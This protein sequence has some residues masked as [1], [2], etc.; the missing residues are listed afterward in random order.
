MKRQRHQI[1]L[2]LVERHALSSQGEV[3]A[4]LAAR[5]VEANQAT[6]SRDINELGLVKVPDGSGGHRYARPKSVSSAVSWEDLQRTLVEHAT[7]V[8]ANESLIV[9]K[10]PPG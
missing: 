7:Q 5:G 4:A 8:L 9:V 6:V 1:L 3:V 2:E 10:T